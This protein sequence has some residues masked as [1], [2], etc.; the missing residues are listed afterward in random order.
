MAA[1][2]LRGALPTSA[3]AR[4]SLGLHRANIL[5]SP[6]QRFG[7]RAFGSSTTQTVLDDYKGDAYPDRISF[8]LRWRDLDALSHVNHA[9]YFTYFEQARCEVW[10]AAGL[11]LDGTGEGPILKSIAAE[12]K[13]PLTFPDEVTIGLF[14]RQLSPRE[15]EQRYACVSH[16]SGRVVATAAAR[17]VNMDYDAGR[18][19]DMSDS[20]QQKLFGSSLAAADG[21]VAP[22]AEEAAAAVDEAHAGAKQKLVALGGTVVCERVGGADDGSRLEFHCVAQLGEQRLSTT[23]TAAPEAGKAWSEALEHEKLEQRVASQLLDAVFS[24][25][26]Y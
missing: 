7:A 3:H 26:S 24:S 19:A 13:A 21:G 23:A 11:I 15:Y 1:I 4:P 8:R 22:R 10:G 2:T 18:P 14:T 16:A 5:R 9:M 17:F 25:D 20:M 6:I 12:F